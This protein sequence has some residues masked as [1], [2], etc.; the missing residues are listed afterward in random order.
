MG[1]FGNFSNGSATFERLRLAKMR[2]A[3]GEIRAVAKKRKK[4]QK[5]VF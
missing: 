5:T 1:S 2:G 3:E 4:A